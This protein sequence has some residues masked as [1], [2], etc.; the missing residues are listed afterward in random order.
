MFN[1]N[2]W[3]VI[4]AEL[5]VLSTI[6]YIALFLFGKFGTVL[7]LIALVPCL[8]SILCL[9]HIWFRSKHRFGGRNIILNLIFFDIMLINQCYVVL[10]Q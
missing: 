8:I 6:N 10:Q 4:S 2:R 1:P 3:F 7:M 5:T 9:I